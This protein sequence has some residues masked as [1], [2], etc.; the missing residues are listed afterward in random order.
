MGITKSDKNSDSIN[1]YNTLRIII[2]Q[3]I[4]IVNNARPISD[5]EQN[6]NF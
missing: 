4:N 6:K 3:N 5:S 2:S 1:V